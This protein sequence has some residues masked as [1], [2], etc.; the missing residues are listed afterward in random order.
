PT[1]LTEAEGNT[2]AAAFARRWVTSRGRRPLARAETSCARTGRSAC[3]PRQM[4]PWAASGR[5]EADADDARLAEVGRAHCT[6]EAAEQGGAVR[7]G[8]GRGTG[9]GRGEHGRAK[10]TPDAEP[11][12]C[13][14]CAR[15]CTPESKTGQEGKVHDAL[16]PHHRQSASRRVPQA[17]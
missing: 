1:L 2:P 12:Q 10:R 3:R 7:C 6:C 14:Q 5:P 11:E 13:A 8:G 16:P 15:L 17:S 4:A 9:P